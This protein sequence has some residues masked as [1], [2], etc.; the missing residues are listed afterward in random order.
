MM[1]EKTQRTKE[2]PWRNQEV[3]E[4]IN[5]SFNEVNLRQDWLIGP[6]TPT[7]VGVSGRAFDLSR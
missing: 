1:S 6:E 7:P 2:L 4:V 5:T 3:E